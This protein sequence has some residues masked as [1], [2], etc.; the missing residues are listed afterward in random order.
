MFA[1]KFYLENKQKIETWKMESEI[2]SGKWQSL[3]AQV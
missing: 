3:C 1:Q 2:K